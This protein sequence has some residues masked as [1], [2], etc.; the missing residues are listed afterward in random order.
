LRIQIRQ[1]FA[2]GDDTALVPAR[3]AGKIMMWVALHNDY[4]KIIDFETESIIT[5]IGSMTFDLDQ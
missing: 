4:L 5:A 3:R 2:T 1:T